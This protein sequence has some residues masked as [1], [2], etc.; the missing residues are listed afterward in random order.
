MVGLTSYRSD[1]VSLLENLRDGPVITRSSG[2][3]VVLEE[4]QERMLCDLP[5]REGRKLVDAFTDPAV[6]YKQSATAQGSF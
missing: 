5:K 4:H 6:R 3:R 2:A 1:L